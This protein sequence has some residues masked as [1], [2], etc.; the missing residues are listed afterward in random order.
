MNITINTGNINNETVQTVNARD[1]HEYLGAKDHYAT[2]VKDRIEQ[3]GFE[4][5]GDFVVIRE[6]PKNSSGGRP[7]IDH[8]ISLDMAKEL[9]MVERNEKGK[10]ARQYFIECERLAKS[11]ATP[12]A[13]D[14]SDPTV[15]LGVVTHLKE[16]KEAAEAKVVRLL[17]KAEV[18]D[19]LMNADGL[20][21]LQNAGRALS[22]RPNLFIRWLKQTFLFYQGGSL[23]P[24]VQYTQRGL[25]EVKTTIVD[26]KVRPA[27]YVTPKGLEF[28]R[29]KVPADLMIGGAA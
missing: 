22:A 2:W 11:G 23:V 3:Y 4:E 28:F 20:Y 18:Y 24:R 7:R 16:A 15:M 13:I 1:L 27:T 9:S 17:P 19:A 29:K 12:K 25:F 8:H 6:I 14:Y 26:D 21:G 10:E 5:D